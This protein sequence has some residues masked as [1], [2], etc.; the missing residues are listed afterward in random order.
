MTRNYAASASNFI[1]EILGKL[2][3]NDFLVVFYYYSIINGRTRPL[4]GQSDFKSFLHVF[5]TSFYIILK[6]E[7]PGM[8]D[9]ERK[10]ELQE[11]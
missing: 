2:Q 3:K 9:F 10:Q 6:Q 8:Y 7:R 1:R 11:V 4:K 5:E